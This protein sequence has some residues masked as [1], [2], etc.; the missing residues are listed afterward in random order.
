MILPLSNT[1]FDGD[2]LTLFYR[3]P[4][5]L[6]ENFENFC[7]LTFAAWSANGI[8]T[9]FA[10]GFLASRG[11]RSFQVVQKRNHWWHTR[12]IYRVRDFVLKFVQQKSA[13]LVLYG[14]SM[15]GYGSFHLG[16]QFDAWRTISIAPQFTVKSESIPMDKRWQKEWSAIECEFGEESAFNWAPPAGCFIFMDRTHELDHLHACHFEHQN[17]VAGNNLINVPHTLHD[18]ARVLVNSKVF[19]ELLLS[20]EIFDDDALLHTREACLSVFKDNPKTLLNFLRGN[21]SLDEHYPVDAVVDLLSQNERSLDFE[22]MYFAAEFFLRKAAPQLAIK[23]SDLSISIY[24]K[25]NRPEYLIR[26]HKWI[27]DKCER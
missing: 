9:P 2:D 6:N 21:S 27:I 23:Y 20:R 15:G 22:A 4:T 17:V 5:K 19:R 16:I 26:K 13:R 11:I 10:Q 14:S 7:Y 12:E 3:E 18:C 25:M 8:G 24:P 1:V